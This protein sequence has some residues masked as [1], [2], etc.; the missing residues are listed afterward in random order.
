MPGP[1]DPR[2]EW[3][4]A[5]RKRIGHLC[6]SEQVIDDADDRSAAQVMYEYDLVVRQR[7]W[8]FWAAFA[9]CGALAV[10]FAGE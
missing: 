10:A 4:Y 1:T 6:R 9:L 7:L 8:A 5:E 3:S 2:R